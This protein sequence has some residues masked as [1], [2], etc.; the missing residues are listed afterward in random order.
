MA[1]MAE[2]RQH[3]PG[4]VMFSAISALRQ[5]GGMVTAVVQRVDSSRV[6]VRG[7]PVNDVSRI[8]AFFDPRTEPLVA[9]RYGGLVGVASGRRVAASPGK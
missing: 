4:R 7:L 8:S 6:L 9:A 1:A 5:E 2:E 3:L